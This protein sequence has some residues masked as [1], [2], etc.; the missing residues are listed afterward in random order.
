MHSN[1]SNQV[2]LERS[3]KLAAIFTAVPPQRDGNSEMEEGLISISFLSIH[4]Q[5]KIS[6]FYLLKRRN[7]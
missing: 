6:L 3:V 5:K 4:R 2:L 1:S 7:V